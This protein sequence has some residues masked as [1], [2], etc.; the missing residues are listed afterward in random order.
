MKQELEQNAARQ[1]LSIEEYL[2]ESFKVM[3]DEDKKK[4][5]GFVRESGIQMGIEIDTYE[6]IKDAIGSVDESIYKQD[7]AIVSNNK[8][9]ICSDLGEANFL[10][11]SRYQRDKRKIEMNDELVE[12]YGLKRS[13]FVVD[14]NDMEGECWNVV[15]VGEYI[16]QLLEIEKVQHFTDGEIFLLTQ[17]TRWTTDAWKQPYG[18]GQCSFTLFGV[19]FFNPRKTIHQSPKDLRIFFH[20]GGW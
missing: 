6:R 11:H 4:M 16:Q 8:F 12:Q 9:A 7:D 1:G 13:A 10:Q 5:A 20:L 2:L 18:R 14:E 17:L 3:G 19:K 15:N